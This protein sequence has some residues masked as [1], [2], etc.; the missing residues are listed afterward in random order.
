M[1]KTTTAVITLALF[2]LVA[3]AQSVQEFLTNFMLFS[4]NYVIPFLIGIAFVFF[5]FNAIRFFVIGGSNE[6]GKEK[7]KAL[8]IYGVSAFVLIIIFWG[9]INLLTSS[10]GLDDSEVPVSDY[11]QRII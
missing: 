3:S 4:S 7:A 5:V 6:E 1:R 8:A 2:P 9:I 11:M 10:L